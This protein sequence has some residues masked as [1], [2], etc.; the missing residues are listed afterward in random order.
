[1]FKGILTFFMILSVFLG[2]SQFD[3]EDKYVK[4]FIWGVTTNTNSSLIGGVVFR[5]G[6]S[7]KEDIF[8]LSV[9]SW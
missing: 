2:F 3:D 8:E 5:Y 1:M 7:H 6:R 4:E 9:L